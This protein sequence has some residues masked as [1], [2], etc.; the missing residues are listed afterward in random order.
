MATYRLVIGSWSLVAGG[1]A[2][3]LRF[4][5]NGMLSF[6]LEAVAG[7][8]RARAGRLTTLHGAVLTPIFM[9]VGTQA[10]VKGLTV[11]DLEAAGSRVL[12]AN[13]YHLLLRPGV[14]VFE[15]VGGIHQF[16]NWKG[17]VLTDSGGFQIFS[18][19]NAREMS[20]EGASF[21]SHVDGR[22]IMLTPEFSV[23]VQKAIG[24]DIMMVLDQCIPSTADHATAVAAMALTHRWAAR[25][26]AA[27]GDSPQ[28]LFGIV[29]GACYEDLRRESAKALTA[30]PF[31]GFAIGGLAVGE[32]KA[33]REDF[34]A[35]T[36]E[37]L[38]T[39]QP[40]YLM[41]VGSPI[42]LLEAVHRGVD[43][44]DC[45][46]P[47]ALAKQ[48]I[49]F[50]SAGRLDLYRGVYK[51]A[52]ETLDPSCACTTCAAYSRAY[53]HHLTKAGEVLGWQLLTRHNLHFYHGLMAA[54][55]RHILAGTFAAFY[56]EQ[57]EA[58]VRGD[59]TNPA[60]P[61]PAKRRRD[62][63]AVERFEVRLSDEGFAYI[64]DKASGEK[65]HAGLN[66][67]GE[68]EALYVGQSRLVERQAK[69]AAAELVVWDVGLGAAHN[70]MAAVRALELAGGVRPVRL[71]SFE[72]DMGSLRLA[73]KNAARFP[74]LQAAAPNHLLR[75]GEWRSE[76][77][78][79]VWQLVE[80]DFLAS[81]AEAPVPD[82]IFYDPFSS[83]TDRDLWTYD[84]FAK[85]HAVC[86]EHDTE[87]FTY[88]AG[89]AVRAALLAAGFFVA[90][91]A[92]T[93]TK[94]ET[95]IA[96]TPPAALSR[97]TGNR[98][99]LPPDW[100]ERWRRSDARYP[101]DVPAEGQAEFA[102]RIEGHAQFAVTQSA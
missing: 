81:L 45:I 5:M 79:L 14:E 65:M 30:M 98:K 84:C 44:F 78:P 100:L 83:K 101:A 63:G 42:D 53:L 27:R 13:T 92:P 31:D 73:L 26:L 33:Q 71:V 47:S 25:S 41:G 28:A 97:R 39:D 10:T 55:R 23:A 15:K 82:L 11:E 7:E 34:T 4:I 21:R 1:G 2:K 85:L 36:A 88:A 89:T 75:F 12:L 95:T 18:L 102:A 50:T 93:G 40:R 35:L 57:R 74:H 96:L 3:G 37:L 76:R 87:L 52:D 43:M 16:M 22:R 77:A 19:A 62:A 90:Q 80:D 46:L 20:E 8:S 9:P 51:L 91:G 64:T 68:A 69:D 67:D 60:T 94:R 56:R 72:N 59:D 17:G 58:L 6:T 32:T 38:P 49:A 29:Q 86:A 54:M 99:L 61:P 48:G 70:A 66:P 24:S